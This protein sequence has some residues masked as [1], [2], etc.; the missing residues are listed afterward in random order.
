MGDTNDQNIIVDGLRDG[1]NAFSYEVGRRLAE[2][3]PGLGI[4]CTKGEPDVEEFSKTGDCSWEP[5]TDPYWDAITYWIKDHGIYRSL[6]NGVRLV[7]WRGQ[8]LRLFVL[9]VKGSYCDEQWAWV[10]APS[11]AACEEFLAVIQEW[12]HELRSEVLVFDH[13][14]WQKSKSLYSSIKSATFENLILPEDLKHEIRADFTTFFASE[15]TYEQYSVPWKRG[16]LLYGDPGNGKTHTLK[17]IIN[18]HR[19]NALYVRSFIARH[20]TEEECIASVFER[21]RESKPCILIFEDLDSLINDRNR[22]YFLNELDGFASN[23]GIFVVASTNH[24]E[25]LDPAIVDRPSRFDRKYNFPLPVEDLRRQFLALRNSEVAPEL[26]LTEDELTAIA[27]LTDGFSFAYLKELWLSSI[28]VWINGERY[29]GAMLG[30]M[31]SQ[32]EFLREQ[33]TKVHECESTDTP[34]DH[35]ESAHFA[36]FFASR[37]FPHIP[38]IAGHDF[39]E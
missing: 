9:T 31:K 13:G 33:M 22:S 21:A 1:T 38:N 3:Y 16:V 27:A 39:A 14:D 36:R 28:M 10:V 35:D 26:Q 32:I 6:R 29:A 18:S 8:E 37:A 7:R 25:R 12:S 19:V 15:S 34:P 23:H 24:P 17:A 20:T 2:L 11:I 30:V 5:A 4:L